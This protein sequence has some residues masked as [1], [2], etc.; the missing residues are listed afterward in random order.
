[1]SERVQLRQAR[2]L[3]IKIGSALLTNDGK[4]LDVA[5]LGLWVDQIVALIQDG[6]EV[7]LV[8]S[9][10]VAEGMSRLG[11]SARPQQLHELQ[12]AAAVG[13]MGLVQTWEAQF[14]RHGIHAAQILLT[15]DDLSDRKR[16]LN[17]RSTL[18]ALLDFGVVPI[19]NENDTV[20]TD[21][22]RFGD[23]DTLGA[24]VANLIEAD[25][26]IILTDQLGLFDKDPRKHQDARLVAERKAGDRELD[27]MAGGGAGALGRGGM[28]TK[29]RAARLA[30][31]SGAFT[32]IVGGRIEG[33]ITRLRQGDVIGTLL[34]PEQGRV[35]ARKQWL[36]SH[37]QTRGKLTLDDGAVRVLCLGGR[38]LLPVGVKGVVGQF[39]RGEMVSCI[40]TGGREVARGLINYDAD[41]ARAIAGQSSD[42]I[43]G[44]LG[45]ISDEEMIHRDNLVIV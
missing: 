41:E 10:S 38:S 17:G 1:M 32:V 7:V 35:A 45:Y 8:S 13:Q 42:R 25:G 15:H 44:V 23:N 19:V 11:W 22:I 37:L 36:A 21:E 40:D 24:L 31:R 12:A 20:V 4:G 28:Q 30:A 18:R 29:V 39:R 6:V 43:V 9:G 2:R 33:V 14:K 3:V 27:V 34:L 5:S 16:Y 26:L